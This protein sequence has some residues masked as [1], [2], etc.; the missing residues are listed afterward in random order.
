MQ[1]AD[2]A[3]MIEGQVVW[4]AKIARNGKLNIRPP[5]RP[6]NCESWTSTLQENTLGEIE[7]MVL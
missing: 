7:N 1:D 4:L 2:D 5:R 3:L 6:S